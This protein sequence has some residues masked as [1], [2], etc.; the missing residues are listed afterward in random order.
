[1]PVPDNHI[2]CRFIKRSKSHWSTEKQRPKPKAFHG[3]IFSV[4]DRDALASMGS[5]L[6]DLQFDNLKRTGQAQHFTVDYYRYADEVAREQN[7]G[8][9]VQVEYRTGD[10]DVGELWYHWRDA[11]AQV[12]VIEQPPTFPYDFRHK[13]AKGC[14]IAIAP[15][16]MESPLD[17]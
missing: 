8:F 10:D 7:V 9:A 5:T 12:E 14:Y 11:H 15:D 4:W 13:L 17:R 1:M 3:N 16:G 6:A 2:V